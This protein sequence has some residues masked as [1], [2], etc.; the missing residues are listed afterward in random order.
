MLRILMLAAGMLLNAGAQAAE[1]TGKLTL[2]CQGTAI[3][4]T[5]NSKPEPISMGIIVDFAARTVE[6]GHEIKSFPVGITDIT[7]TAIS[8]FGSD[9]SDRT[10]VLMPNINGAI[11][12]VT[13]AVEADFFTRGRGGTTTC[14]APGKPACTYWM[15]TYSLK[16]K[17]TQR[18]F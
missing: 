15:T 16:C 10:T 17:A 3:S 13:G 4:T 1:P 7:E 12:R 18:M 11:D 14:G 6:F 9:W 5:P 2:A 8:F